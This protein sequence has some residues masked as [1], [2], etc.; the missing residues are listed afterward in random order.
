MI[1]LALYVVHLHLPRRVHVFISLN[2]FTALG[3]ALRSDFRGSPSFNLVANLNI[4]ILRN[5]LQFKTFSIKTSGGW[6]FEDFRRT[7][8]LYRDLS[9]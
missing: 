5:K 6:L 4:P 7:R 8:R 1:A 2:Q 9:P 3:G